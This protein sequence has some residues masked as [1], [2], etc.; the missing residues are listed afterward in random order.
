MSSCVWLIS[1]SMMA[2]FGFWFLFTVYMVLFIYT[3]AFF[4]F[5]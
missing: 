5:F 4:D 1:L 3:I 2:R